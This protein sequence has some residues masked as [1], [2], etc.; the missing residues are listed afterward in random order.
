MRALA[1][2]AAGAAA[3]GAAA[4]SDQCSVVTHRAPCGQAADSEATCLVKGCCYDGTDKVN[5][6]FYPGYDAVPIK[7][8]HVVQ[9]NHFDAGFADSTLNILTKWF[10]NFFPLA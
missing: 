5:P 2:L 10:K 8:V 1:L 6:C 4:A 3:A 9:S 7:T